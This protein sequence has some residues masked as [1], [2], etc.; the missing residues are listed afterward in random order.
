MLFLLL[1]LTTTFVVVPFL[2]PLFGREKIQDTA[3]LQSHLFLTK[4]LNRDYVR[5]ELHQVLQKISKDFDSLHPGIKTIYLDANFPF[6]NGF[7]LLPHL[8]HHDGKKID[9]ALIYKTPDGKLTNEKKSRS[10]YGVFVE[11]RENEIKQ[12]LICKQKGYGQYD[13]PKYLT[14]GRTNKNLKFSPE[15]TRDLIQC[16]LKQK[17]IGK[18]FIEPHLKQRMNLTDKRIRFHGC[19]AVR[20]DDHIHIQLE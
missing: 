3:T 14:F 6:W 8:S 11:P 1:Y 20:H 9:L 13:Y 2:A 4:L 7:P 16:I 18:I 10:G 19:R 15:G 12:Y 17:E 5:P